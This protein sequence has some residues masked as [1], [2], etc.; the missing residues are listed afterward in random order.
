M[1]TAEAQLRW[2]FIGE[3]TETAIATVTGLGAGF[4]VGGP[5]CAITTAATF[6]GTVKGR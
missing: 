3:R 6:F 2:Y 4:C 1:T 5:L